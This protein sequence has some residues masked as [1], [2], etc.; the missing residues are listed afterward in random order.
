VK[1]KKKYPSLTLSSLFWCTGWCTSDAPNLLLR[2]VVFRLRG[3][4]RTEPLT[5]KV[6]FRLWRPWCTGGALVAHRISYS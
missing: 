6:D 3:P 4:W 2:K 5:G 1:S